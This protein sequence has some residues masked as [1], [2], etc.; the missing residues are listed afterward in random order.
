[1]ITLAETTIKVACADKRAYFIRWWFNGWHYYQFLAGAE[2]QETT[3]KY[4]ATDSKAKARMAAFH[5]N[6]NEI[7]S[8]RTMLFAK[9]AE[10]L[11]KDGWKAVVI[12]GTT[13]KTFDSRTGG[14]QCEFVITIY[15]KV[16]DYSP[17]KEVIYI[18]D[19]SRFSDVNINQ[20]EDASQRLPNQAHVTYS[21]G[22]AGVASIT[23]GNHDT[24]VLGDFVVS[25]VARDVIGRPI[26]VFI[27]MSVV[28]SDLSILRQIRA[29]NPNGVLP[30]LWDDSKDPYTQWLGVTWRNGRVVRLFLSGDQPVKEDASLIH[31][32]TALEELNVAYNSLK[33]F[34]MTGLKKLWYF[35]IEG[36]DL[37]EVPTGLTSVG[38]MSQYNFSYNFLPQSEIDK[39][40]AMNFRHDPD[41]IKVLLPQKEVQLS[42]VDILKQIRDANP[43]SQLPVMWADSKD[44]F[45][46]WWDEGNQVGVL[47]GHDAKLDQYASDYN[48]EIPPLANRLAD[49]AYVL[50]FHYIDVSDCSKVKK[51]SEL[52]YVEFNIT[53][54]TSISIALLAKVK[55]LYCCNNNLLTSAN[56]DALPS[57]ARLD[58]Y[59]NKAVNLAVTNLNALISFR[60][61]NN[62][63]PSI[64]TL[65][66]R[67]KIMIADLNNNKFTP[68]EVNRLLS[69]GFTASEIGNQNP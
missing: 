22:T 32:L 65:T 27:N 40:I 14:Y 41:D 38:L 30:Y 44:P 46:Q 6:E 63:L 50:V 49:K 9:R 62:L 17:V 34:N 47:F 31:K 11:M 16:A 4:W 68:A 42:D 39:L 10:V 64:P 29:A 25:G 28:E 21:D 18:L 57:L 19:Y 67:G 20:Y 13:L 3:G 55:H 36:N 2:Q 52:V 37:T 48:L 26:Q 53:K 58:F 1:M 24:D 15:A 51:L 54:I 66:S 33:T 60:C 5:L 43:N 59:N 35:H 8:I 7:K 23:W 61:N 56:F 69:I 45:S 12:D